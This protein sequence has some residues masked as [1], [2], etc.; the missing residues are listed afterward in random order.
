MPVDYTTL[1][2]RGCNADEVLNNP[3]LDFSL[4]YN[5]H[6]VV[7]DNKRVAKYHFCK[8]IVFDNGTVLFKGSLHKMYNSIKNIRAPNFSLNNT[9]NGFNGNTFTLENI[10]FI[11]M[12]LEVLFQL[13]R[14][15][16][17]IRKIEI[18]L[19]IQVFF[20]PKLLIDGLLEIGGKPFE[21]KYN[22]HFAVCEKSEYYLKVYDKSNQYGLETSTIRIELKSRKTRVFQKAN[23]NTLA[24]L[25]ACNLDVSLNKLLDCWNKV[26]MYD[27]TINETLLTTRQKNALNNKFQHVKYWQSLSSNNK[28]KPRKAFNDIVKNYSDNIQEQIAQTIK[29][30]KI[31]H[32]N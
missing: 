11:I 23:F 24:D 2:L 14:H 18:G 7:I 28:D 1:L 3:L 19:N 4:N 12:H 8:V 26:L 29:M 17:V 30:T 5:E 6:G 13:S 25:T 10:N 22:N 21:F 32:F 31:S 15:N 9:Y 16:F 20:N 27:F